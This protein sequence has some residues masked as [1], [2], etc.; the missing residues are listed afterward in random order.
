MGLWGT[1]HVNHTSSTACEA[2]RSWQAMQRGHGFSQEDVFCASPPRPLGVDHAPGILT[3]A[4]DSQPCSSRGSPL[5]MEDVTGLLCLPDPCRAAAGLQ[6]RVE[7]P[8][9]HLPTSRNH[10]RASVVCTTYGGNKLSKLSGPPLQDFSSVDCLR[11]CASSEGRHE[12]KLAGA[13]TSPE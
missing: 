10:K 2:S 11:S 8:H 12:D 13:Q 3:A 5:Q 9:C 6:R 7:A 4:L 1:E